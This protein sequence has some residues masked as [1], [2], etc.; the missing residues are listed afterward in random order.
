MTEDC[1]Y[2]GVF[3]GRSQ[4]ITVTRIYTVRG[5]DDVLHTQRLIKRPVRFAGMKIFFVSGS[6]CVHKF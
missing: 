3:M 2:M 4:G 1:S 6:E 5:P